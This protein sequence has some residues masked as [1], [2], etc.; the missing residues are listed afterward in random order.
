MAKK[1][2]LAL[3]LL[4]A[5][6]CV[7]PSAVYAQDQQVILSVREVPV[8]TALGEIDKQTD[9]NVVVNWDLIDPDKRVL[10]PA[11]Q[12]SVREI[13]DWALSGS[14]CS[15]E[16][17]GRQIAIVYRQDE[18]E[19]HSTMHRSSL[20]S[21]MREVIDPWSNK[22]LTVEDLK[23]VRNGYWHYE[24][25]S[26]IDTMS[27]A[28]IHFRVNRTMLER[29]F[30]NNAATLD[31]IHR[32][33][34]NKELLSAM[35]FITITGAAS[36]EGNT[37]ANE[38]LAAD[39]AMAVKSYIMW[40]YPF[41]D[42][43]R[44]FTFSIGEDWSGLRK[45][46]YD[47]RN[48]PRRQ[49]VLNIL[50]NNSDSDAKRA[51]LRQ[52]GGGVAWRYIADNML[53][54]LRGGAACMIYYKEDPEPLVIRETRID[55]VYIDRVKE[56]ERIVEVEQVPIVQGSTPY[57]W[58]IKTN[59]L[60]N[61]VLLP[62]LAVEF[63]IGRKW[64]VEFGGQWSW[65]ATENNHKNCWRIQFAGI[66]TRRWLGNRDDKTPLSGHYLG[67]HGM[68]G[69]Y[70]IRFNNRQGVLSNMSYAVGFSYG[71]ALPIASSWNIQ[72]GIGVGYVGGKYDRYT[73]YNEQE[74]IFYRD[75]RHQRHYFGPT[76]AEISIVWLPGGKNPRKK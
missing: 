54:K 6:L 59:M 72:F 35:E 61:A 48:T 24:A 58:S 21:Q 28:I 17:N 75:S 30:M 29:D 55:T 22:R 43:D 45:M 41:M 14:N 56:I 11:S 65:W 53:P 37:A 57:Y 74:N 23:R 34:S 63:S 18:G 60:Y 40:K 68:A 42:R 44:I 27:L 66:E 51:A 16:I 5:G 32:T 39:R 12:L 31:M 76:K 73:L 33:F 2:N 49:E 1:A 15:W 3:T 4:F 38:R 36:P 9:Y 7:C 71:Y 47:D 50:D 67:L 26:G 46:V 52:I 70:D 19:V 20:P 13:L 25:R 69:T 64:S 62:N 8:R 10:F